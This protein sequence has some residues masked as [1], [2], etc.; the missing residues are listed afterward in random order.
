MSLNIGDVAPEFN[1]KNANDSDGGTSSLSTSMLKNG[2]VVVF[3]CNH[4]PYVIASI[5]RMNNMA[6]YCKVNAIGFVGINSND[7]DNYPADSF[8]NMQKRAGKGM[9]YPYLHDGTQE[10]ATLWGAQRTPEFFLMNGEGVVIYRGRMDDS[11][12]DPTAATTSEL[13]DAIDAMLA[14]S[15]PPVQFTDSI[16][17]SVKWK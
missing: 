17:C 5:D 10:V 13:K 4:C 11:P 1:L 2:C 14:G 9:P 12:R 7:P 3:E 16:G 6:E 15:T 8:E